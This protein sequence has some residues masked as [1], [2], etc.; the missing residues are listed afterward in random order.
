[1]STTTSKRPGP[2]DTQ[3]LSKMS[4]SEQLVNVE[5][6]S[7]DYLQEHVW[8]NVVT[9]V[10]FSVNKG[11]AFGLVGESG[12]GKTTVLRSLLG[13]RHPA[14]RF[15]GGSV[16]FRGRDILQMSRGRLRELR[17]RH[18]A[19]VPQDPT[20]SLTPSMR[21]GNQLIETLKAH[22]IYSGSGE[23][24]KRTLDLFDQVGLPER[25][26]TARKYPHQLSGGQQ[27]RV[28]IAIALACNPDLLLLDEPTT[29][30]DVT[31]QARI[32]SLLVQLR[33]EYD[34]AMIYVTHDLSVISNI[35]DRVGVMYAGDMI[36]EGPTRR[37]FENPSHPYSS[38]LIASI[39]VISGRKTQQYVKLRGMLQR[40]LLP[41]AGCKFAPRCDFVQDQ[42]RTNAQEL[43]TVSNGH[44]VACWRSNDLVL[45]VERDVD[46]SIGP[47]SESQVI[48]NPISNH[49]DH[50][51]IELHEL[52]CAYKWERGRFLIGRHPITVVSGVSFD[53]HRGET[54]GLVG[55]S[56]SG[57]STIA[58][59]VAGL[60]APISG[61][62]SVDNEQL[63]PT[64][65]RRSH[66]SLR[67]IQLVMQNPDASLNPRQRVESI[68][69][70][71]LQLFFG[72]S[73]KN[74]RSRVLDL[75]KDVQL[76]HTYLR[77]FPGEMSGGERQRVA[78]AR[79]LA[80]EPEF[81]LCD[82]IVSALDV[83]V[84]S[85]VLTLL[86]TSQRERN[87]GILF[88]SHDLAVVRSISHR[89][90]VLYGGEL[91][92]IGD[93]DEVYSPPYHPYTHVLLSAVPDIDPDKPIATVRGGIEEEII[94]ETRPACAFANSCPW[95]IGAICDE[96]VPPRR[97]VSE[98]HE[99]R[100]HIPLQ[101]LSALE[102]SV[103]D[104]VPAI[105]SVSDL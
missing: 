13:Y 64:A 2:D 97:K 20:T 105:G 67:R 94:T 16:N 52:E 72:Q 66:S 50:T 43:T 26:I 24:R 69:G 5:G 85:E 79:A 18:I 27:Q 88:I 41:P 93:T 55:E 46:K 7:I 51:R 6:L 84:Q 73:K 87:L 23:A 56:G 59:A 60:I 31:T 10:S 17:G 76:D 37:I 36:E 83:S 40:E 45:S 29:G 4:S 92:E 86:R 75:L 80:A 104:S 68:V 47:D 78:I 22:G 54:L 21:V 19:Y 42:C 11:E 9:N 81:L 74:L 38:G 65:K 53:I 89:V 28:V 96:V 95:K 99:V 82:E 1:M 103:G 14:S 77:R 101:D 3:S 91:M 49:D 98:S 62:M 70:R 35:C 25:N 100:C 15:S 39:P 30:L 102:K 61:E 8:N 90:A 58:K 34:L 44:N 48:R 12:C 32:L 33:S 63:S 57:K 71:P